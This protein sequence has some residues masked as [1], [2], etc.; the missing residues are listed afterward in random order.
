MYPVT[1]VESFSHRHG[2]RLLVS[3]FLFAKGDSARRHHQ[4]F[5]AFVLQ[6]GH[7]FDDGR[8]S[9]QCQ[10]A[11]V[12]PRDDSRPFISSTQHMLKCRKE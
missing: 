11:F 10:T 2:K 6:L 1:L 7:L 5:T 9:A 3:Q 12:L 4:T 8:Q